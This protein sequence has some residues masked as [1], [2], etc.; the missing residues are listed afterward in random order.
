MSYKVTASTRFKKSMKNY[1][2][3]ASKK[4]AI[5]KVID[6]LTENGYQSIPPNMYPHKLKG[7]YA[8]CWECHIQPDLLLIWK[9][10]ENPEKE[11]LL[12]DVGSHSDLF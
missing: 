10:F 9:Q 12:V 4:E 11:I 7:N 5:G 2:Y 3:I 8:G 1:F 6:L